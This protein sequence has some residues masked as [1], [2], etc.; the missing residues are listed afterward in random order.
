MSPENLLCYFWLGKAQVPSVLRALKPTLN[1]IS[2]PHTPE[3]WWS[4]FRTS[5]IFISTLSLLSLFGLVG[6][7][8]GLTNPIFYKE[9]QGDK[10][11][12]IVHWQAKA[13]DH[14][15]HVCAWLYKGRNFSIRCWDWEH[16]S[17]DT[18]GGNTHKFFS[19]ALPITS[20]WTRN[21]KSNK[22]DLHGILPPFNLEPRAKDDSAQ[23]LFR[24][25]VCQA[26]K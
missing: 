25:W 26:V 3:S 15:S 2:W 4:I 18:R 14:I 12:N 17:V 19:S 22:L 5:A 23:G 11:E 21:S 1:F 10:V 9:T 24:E 6:I 16:H 7:K 20:A 13:D 8:S